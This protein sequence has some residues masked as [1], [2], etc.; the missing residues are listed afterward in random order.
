MP[1][2]HRPGLRNVL[3][4]SSRQFNVSPASCRQSAHVTAATQFKQGVY[5]R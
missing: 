5:R 1:C 2:R 3:Q 4:A